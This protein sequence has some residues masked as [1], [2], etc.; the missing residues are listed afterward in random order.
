MKRSD[1]DYIALRFRNLQGPQQWIVP[2]HNV[3]DCLFIGSTGCLVVRLQNPKTGQA[4]RQVIFTQQR[5]KRPYPDGSI[6]FA[7]IARIAAVDNETSSGYVVFCTTDKLSY[8][9][10]QMLG[11]QISAPDS[12]ARRVQKVHEITDDC[13]YRL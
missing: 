6:R 12:L 8:R 1:A 3:R 4:E 11:N 5:I 10:E 9:E 2:I 13:I 7:H